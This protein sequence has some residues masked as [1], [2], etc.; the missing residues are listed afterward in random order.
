DEADAYPFMAVGSIAPSVTGD[1]ATV[2][3]FEGMPPC[4]D[5]ER[6]AIA[7]RVGTEGIRKTQFG[8]GLDEVHLVHVA[9]VERVLAVVAAGILEFDGEAQWIEAAAHTKIDTRAE[10]QRLI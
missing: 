1:Q 4:P 3:H 2:Q 8:E 9:I 6:P 5:A 7:A 10:Q